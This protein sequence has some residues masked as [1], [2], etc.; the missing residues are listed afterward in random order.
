MSQAT[1][2][3][4][5]AKGEEKK[6]VYRPFRVGVQDTDDEPY[7]V[8]TTLGSAPRWLTPQYDIPSTG[9]L[10]D[11]YVLVENQA[12]NT[13]TATGTGAVGVLAEDGPYS[14]IASL[15]FTDTSSSEIIGP[16]TG[17][18]LYIID[19][20]GGYMFQ[21]DPEASSDLFS[22]SSNATASAADAGSFLFFLRIPAQLVPRDA[23]GT[24]PNKSQSTPYK[25]KIQIAAKAD[26]Y[27]NAATPDGEIRVRMVPASYWEPTAVDGSGNPVSPQPPAVNTTQYWSKNEY[28]HPGGKFTIPLTN[29]VGYPVRNLVFI[30]RT[31]G[32]RADG[33][34]DFPTDDFILQLQSNIIFN[35]FKGYWLKRMLEDYGYGPIGDGAGQKD[36]GVYVLPFCRDF[37]PKPG[38]ETRRGYLRTSDGMK[39]L[40]KGTWDDTGVTTVLTNYVG[41]GAGSSLAAVTT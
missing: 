29:S 23:L 31:D 35:R 12:T 36:N 34:G 1:K 33:E 16:I 5:A 41:I 17:Y 9:F 15:T 40:A 25:V 19:K 18:D 11:V 4:P 21:D 32:S 10:N 8:T 27:V 38:W 37:G 20:W 14:A 30:E 2:D 28:Q 13:A 3:A 39:L 22:S 7:D 24:L 6:I 26:V